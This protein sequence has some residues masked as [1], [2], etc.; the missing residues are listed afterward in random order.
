MGEQEK[1]G[2]V[3]KFR[4]ECIHLSR[5]HHPNI[6]Q[7]IGV[8]YTRDNRL[9][10]IMEFLPTS[11]RKCL[12]RCSEEHYVIPTCFKVS[13]LRDVS[14]GLTY[15]HSLN[16][17]HRDLS[18][19]NILLTSDMRA[20]IAD[21]GMSKILSPLQQRQLTVSPGAADIMPP[22]ALEKDRQYTCKIDIFS[23]GVMALY[24]I[25][26]EYPD[27][28]Q[29]GLEH[30]HLDNKEI[31][32]GKRMRQIRKLP[33]WSVR[34]VRP[35][36]QDLPERRPEATRLRE[37]FEGMCKRIPCQYKDTIQMLQAI[38]QLVSI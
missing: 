33:D 4:E 11:L 19:Q 37:E 30:H 21:L 10:L 14:T 24:L 25:V 5:L 31:E 15:L 16:L 35:C 13:I 20:K 12:V 17:A 18:A 3:Q 26:Q 1:C 32:I 23:F 22:E 34:I 7:F 8:H 2:I 6:V 36:L 9:S 38:S 27:V 29:S 28:V